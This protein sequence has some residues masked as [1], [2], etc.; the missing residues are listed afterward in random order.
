MASSTV[1][2][3][4]MSAGT[5]WTVT[6]GVPEQSRRRAPAVHARPEPGLRRPGIMAARGAPPHL[7]AC[8]HCARPLSAPSGQTIELLDMFWP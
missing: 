1:A 8:N 2:R 4:A 7:W 3:A 5:H 6:G